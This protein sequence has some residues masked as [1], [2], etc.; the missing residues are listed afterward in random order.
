MCSLQTDRPG[1][2]MSIQIDPTGLGLPRP[3]LYR[4][5]CSCRRPPVELATYDLTGRI[6]I[7]PHDRY[8]QI[9][10]RIA[11]NCPKCGKQHVLELAIDPALVATLPLPWRSGTDA[12][13]E[14]EP[15]NEKRSR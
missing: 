10:S 2:M 5:E 8:W 9:N 4:W 11:T 6:T 3:P 14:A 7:G 13:R 1:G 12:K 15:D